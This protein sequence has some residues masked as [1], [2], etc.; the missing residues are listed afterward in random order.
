MARRGRP[1]KG[2]G[3]VDDLDGERL[4]KE[5]LKAI[6]GTVT[7]EL[8]V[9]EACE[10]LGIGEA[11]FY[12]LRQAALAAAVNGLAP[13]KVGRPPKHVPEESLRVAALEEQVKLLEIDLQAACVREELAVAMP[14]LL[15]P[16]GESPSKK[17][18]RTRS[19]KRKAARKARKRNRNR[20]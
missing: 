10:E 15:N 18:E 7:G 4:A 9:P 3:L 13:R 8:S 12:Q 5:K 2:S 19:R 20:G 11:R 17:N 14:H 16:R 1:P 6:L